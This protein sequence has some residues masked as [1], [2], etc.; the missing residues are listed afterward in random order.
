MVALSQSVVF[1]DDFG[2]PDSPYLENGW[3]EQ[4]EILSVTT[5]PSGWRLGPGYIEVADESLVFHYVAATYF[6]L[7]GRP[8][9]YRDLGRTLSAYPLKLHFTYSPQASERVHHEIGLMNSAEGFSQLTQL[10]GMG[11][12]WTGQTFNVPN[13]GIGVFLM[14]S[15]SFTSNSTIQVSQ[16][17]NGN[18]VVLAQKA[19]SFQ[20]EDPEVYS[21]D[22]SLNPDGSIDVDIAGTSGADHLAASNPFFGVP[23]DRLYIVDTEGGPDSRAEVGSDYLLR[24]DDIAVEESYLAVAIDIKPFETPNSINL[25]SKGTISVALFGS[26]MLEASQIDPATIR[27][28]GAQVQSHRGKLQFSLEDV[29][30]DGLT[31]MVVHIVASALELQ[32]GDSEAILTGSTFSGLMIRG[33]DTVRIVR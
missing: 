4:N 13:R 2:R 9:V 18:K 24:F 32:P 21:V 7:C 25:G 11:P 26:S 33:K 8:N 17:D 22:L 28:A 15:G 5:L 12:S 20:L 23:L 3:V 30:G 27:L 6:N 16:L 1:E 29:N 10:T 31:D 14:K 19:L